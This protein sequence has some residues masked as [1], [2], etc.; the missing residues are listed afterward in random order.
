MPP[1][2]LPAADYTFELYN[3]EIEYVADLGRI[4]SAQ[5]VKTVN[6][7]GIQS[8]GGIAEILHAAETIEPLGDKFGVGLLQLQEELIDYWLAI[9][10]R[11][12]GI[13]WLLHDTLWGIRRVVKSKQG[14]SKTYLLV[15]YSADRHILPSRE[16]LYASGTSQAKKTDQ[17]DDMQ[18]AVVND[19]FIT[20]TVSA[21]NLS[22]AYFGNAADLSAGPTVDK[23][24]AWDDVPE[25]LLAIADTSAS[26]DTTP[27][28]LYWDIEASL[29]SSPTFTFK[30][31]T[32]QRGAD[33]SESIEFS[34]ANDNLTK[35]DL[36]V[37]WTGEYNH[38]TAAGQGEGADRRT[39]TA[40]ATDRSGR[41][42]LARRERL[43]NATNIE[44]DDTAG[45]QDEANALLEEGRPRRIFKAD[46]V[47]TPQAPFGP[48]GWRLGDRVK[49]VFDDEVFTPEVKTVQISIE[50]GA[51]R[52]TARLSNV[53]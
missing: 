9:W 17:A 8:G 32:G 14:Q 11:Q 2:T 10:V 24:F 6:G 51:A 30:T 52:V 19:N 21:R 5:I 20:A 1:N 41:G 40:E 31:Y 43:K 49:A 46:A 23:S 34:E 26:H 44:F 16:I 39:A 18:K 13:R 48:N 50:G 37:D 3:R 35:T 38:A 45:L 4:V 28:R 12:L 7:P 22:S 53:D 42:P 33:R 36:D 29:T 47:D 27:T 15:A 25:T